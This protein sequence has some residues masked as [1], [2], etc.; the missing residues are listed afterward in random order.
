MNK[1]V[2]LTCAVTG[3]G[4]SHLK[5]NG[6]PGSPEEIAASA[7]EAAKAGAAIVHLHARDPKTRN[8]SRDAALYEEIVKL[9]RSSDTD[10]IINLT[11]AVGG[12]F[13]PNSEDAMKMGEESDL[14]LPYDRIE[15]IRRTKPEICT[16]DCGTFNDGPN[17][18]YLATLDTLRE[19]AKLIGELGVLP[20]VEAFD[21]GH[22]WQAKI[23]MKENLLPENTMFQ[24]CMG[25]AY[26]A[27][28]TVSNVLAM[29][30]ALPDN[31]NW[32]AFGV[33]ANEF[34]MLAQSIIMGGNARVGL[35]DNI[36]LD[37][38]VYATNAQLVEKGK[39]IIEQL[40]GKLATPE[41]ARKKLGLK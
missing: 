30:N 23:L 1:N 15:H 21:L 4:D 27:E 8:P 37:K 35:E 14:L 7:I 33:G 29:K 17:I 32:G 12:D 31:V 5:Y 38:G 11:S 9:I 19:C 18:A 13:V 20:E 28:P 10:V 34:P 24:L 16:F 3:G 36:Y 41:E 2:I 39:N 25:V 26:C 22:L 40:G 6:V